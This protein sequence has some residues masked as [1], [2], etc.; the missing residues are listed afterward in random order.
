MAIA[1]DC[2][3]TG[4]ERIEQVT[5]ASRQALAIL[6]NADNVHWEL[7]P[8]LAYTLPFMAIAWVYDR[9]SLKIKIRAVIGW[10]IFDAVA[11]AV[12]VETLGWI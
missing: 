12:L 11:W 3:T 1:A 9:L 5:E 4:G 7:I 8:M 2:Q 10:A 6:R